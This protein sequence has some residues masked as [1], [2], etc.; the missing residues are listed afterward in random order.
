MNTRIILIMVIV[1]VGAGLWWWFQASSKSDPAPRPATQKAS[2]PRPATQKT[3]KPRPISGEDAQRAVA[4]GAFLLDVRTPGEFSQ[5]H[6][7]GAVNIPVAELSER[8]QELPN[9]DSNIVVYCKS[10]G[11]SGR[12][13]QLLEKSGFK[14]VLNLG[15]MS[16]WP[17]P[18]QTHTSSVSPP[19]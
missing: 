3:S 17:R 6:I 1:G 7:D 18:T 12:A 13:Q 19:P 16:R 10:G 2:K 5:G 11:R 15:G 8:L 9:R 14:N 4:A